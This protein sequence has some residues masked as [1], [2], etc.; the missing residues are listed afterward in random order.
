MQIAHQGAALPPIGETNGPTPA[1]RPA[2]VVDGRAD[3]LA[4]RDR[5]EISGEARQVVAAERGQGGRPEDSTSEEPKTPGSKELTADEKREVEQLKARDLEV[6]AH[7]QAHTAAL[8]GGSAR[9]GY[10]VGPDG[11]RYAVEG[12]VPVSIKSTPGNPEQTIAEA[13]KVARAA[14]APAQPSGADFSAR[15]RALEVERRARD[16]LQQEQAEESRPQDDPEQPVALGA[17]PP[18]L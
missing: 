2:T 4:I 1:A 13:Q 9:F 14:T 7:E 18:K 11:N 12:E 16:E 6:R 15:A 10:E 8:G 3:G 5:V 17:E